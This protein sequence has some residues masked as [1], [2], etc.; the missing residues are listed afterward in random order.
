VK[1]LNNLLTWSLD[2]VNDSPADILWGH[3]LEKYIGIE[4]IITFPIILL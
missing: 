2:M 1:Q 3:F 4:G